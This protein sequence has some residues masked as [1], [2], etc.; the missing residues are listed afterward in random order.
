MFKVQC[1]RSEK[2]CNVEPGTLNLEHPYAFTMPSLLQTQFS[3][4][5]VST[6]S[7]LPLFHGDTFRQISRLVNVRAAMNRDVISEQL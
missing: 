1:S 7:S 3:L 4:T 2:S 5:Q 6:E